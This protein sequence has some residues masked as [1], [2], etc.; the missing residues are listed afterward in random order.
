MKKK[1]QAYHSHGDYE[2]LIIESAFYGRNGSC[3]A[4]RCIEVL[5][6]LCPVR[7]PPI[8]FIRGQTVFRGLR[9]EKVDCFVDESNQ[10]KL[11]Q[12]DTNFLHCF[13]LRHHAS[14]SIS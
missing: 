4:V 1:S 8:R 11:V 12:E 3:T 14:P 9:P 6:A 7:M 10:I 5:L 2:F 13:L